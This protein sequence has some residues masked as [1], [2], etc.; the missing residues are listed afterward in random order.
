MTGEQLA[1]AAAALVGTRFRLGGR[2]PD[3]GLDCIGLLEAALRRCDHQV[4][5][6]HGYTLR[7]ST[8]TK[9]LPVPEDYGFCESDGQFR[10]GDV[11]LLSPGCQQFHLTICAGKTGWVHAHAGLG[12]VVSQTER[13]AGTIIRHWRL[14]SE[15]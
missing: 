5:L 14:L 8:P 7:V 13:P 12:R 10:A 4:T 2:E 9:W 15:K 11:V 3:R 1:A 6:P